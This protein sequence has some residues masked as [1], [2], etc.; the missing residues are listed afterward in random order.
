MAVAHSPDT[1][2]YCNFN[3][4][5]TFDANYIKL[6]LNDLSIS[7]DAPV[8][9][10]I[11]EESVTAPSQG[12]TCS[13]Q[14]PFI[15]LL[16]PKLG[17]VST[18]S[19]FPL[20]KTGLSLK[21]KNDIN[22]YL[23]ADRKLSGTY[24]DPARNYAIEIIKSSELSS[25]SVIAAGYLGSHVYGDLQLVRINLLNPITLNS[26][27]CQTP[28][29]RVEMGDDYRLVDFVNAG[30]TPRTIKFNIDL[31][32]CQAGIKA[33]TY[34]LKATSQVLDQKK[35]LVALSLDSTAKG[36]GLQLMNETGQP[37]AL[38]TTYAFSEFDPKGTNFKI[39]LSA[40]YYRLADTKLEA[41]T[42]NASVTFIV[43][44]L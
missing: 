26:A 27:S 30:D 39:P 19:V 20:G 24:T 16:D 28:S 15:F 6:P 2:A 44:Y 1:F 41:G 21:V 17:S 31:K 23:N 9:T 7:A 25:Q 12:F 10:V 42:A 37:L 36:V 34:S 38:D 8:G 5:A 4:G 14:S 3:Q 40:A 22:G 11:Y 43:N 29:V 33:V 35:G 13:D 32:E 18:G